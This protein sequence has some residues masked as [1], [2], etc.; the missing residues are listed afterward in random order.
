MARISRKSN[1]NYIWGPVINIGDDESLQEVCKRKTDTAV[2]EVV[3][4][5]PVRCVNVTPIDKHSPLLQSLIFDLTSQKYANHLDT[6][7][8]YTF[9][10]KLPLTCIFLP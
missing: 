3:L 5:L 4:L 9:K 1:V 8:N 10:M 6:L 7:K 2:S